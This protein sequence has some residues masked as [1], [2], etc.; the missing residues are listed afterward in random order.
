[1]NSLPNLEDGRCQQLVLYSTVPH[2]SDDS[3]NSSSFQNC[4]GPVT[5]WKKKEDDSEF[6]EFSLHPAVVPGFLKEFSNFSPTLVEDKAIL[7]FYGPESLKKVIETL[8]LKK[9][10][11]ED[12]I[13]NEVFEGSLIVSSFIFNF[14]TR[15][16]GKHLIYNLSI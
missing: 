6:F 3:G 2:N 11:K 4:L 16:E 8:K 9:D 10:E 1:M 5:I 7:T 15:I 13:F 12:N 14:S